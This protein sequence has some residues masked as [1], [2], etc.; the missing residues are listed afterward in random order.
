MK[1]NKAPTKPQRHE[2]YKAAL[3]YYKEIDQYNHNGICSSIA[4][5]LQDTFGILGKTSSNINP[6]YH[7]EL[8]PEIV[9][10]KPS[11]KELN[12]NTYWFDSHDITI[13]IE[14]FKEAIIDSQRKKSINIKSKTYDTSKKINR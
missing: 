9:K 10:H 4:N 12:G 14:I 7:M 13:R 2:I 5:V 11:D 3:K 1:I 8:Y 6:Y